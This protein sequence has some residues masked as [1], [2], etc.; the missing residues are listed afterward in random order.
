MFFLFSVPTDFGRW[1]GRSKRSKLT[2]VAPRARR[3]PTAG[4]VSG[5]EDG[6]FYSISVTSYN[7]MVELLETWQT[8]EVNDLKTMSVSE[9]TSESDSEREGRTICKGRQGG[10]VGAAARFL[11]VFMLEAVETVSSPMGRSW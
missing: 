1:A 10:F 5:A 9:R 11:E 4:H 3:G 8:I 2:R 7:T 6:K